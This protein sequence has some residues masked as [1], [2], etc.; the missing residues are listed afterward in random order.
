MSMFSDDSSCSHDSVDSDGY[1]YGCKIE[2]F[3]DLTEEE[4]KLCS[5]FILMSGMKSFLIKASKFL[6]VKVEEKH[7]HQLLM[8]LHSFEQTCT[9]AVVRRGLV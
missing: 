4:K 9:N 1:D 2:D 6:L 5:R 7:G 8:N 3:R